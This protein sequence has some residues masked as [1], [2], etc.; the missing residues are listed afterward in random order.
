MSDSSRKQDA[1]ATSAVATKFTAQELATIHAAAGRANID[2]IDLEKI[3]RLAKTVIEAL[4][5]ILAELGKKKA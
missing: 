1:S 5:M 2:S 4:Q 3:L